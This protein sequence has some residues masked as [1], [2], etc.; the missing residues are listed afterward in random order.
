M[1]DAHS[2]HQVRPSCG[3]VRVEWTLDGSCAFNQA[4][5]PDTN[6]LVHKM[7]RDRFGLIAT[8]WGL[9]T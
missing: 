5:R 3:S 2:G 4:A 6:D 1:A 9:Q 7:V 8:G